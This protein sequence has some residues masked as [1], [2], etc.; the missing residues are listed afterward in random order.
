MI[1]TCP[2]CGASASAD[3][4][5]ANADARKA[6][7][8][9]SDI[10]AQVQ[11]VAF[12][13]AAMFR[14]KSRAMSWRQALRRLTEI[15]DMTGS[16]FV[17]WKGRPARPCMPG[18]WAQAVAEMTDSRDI[19]LPL[20]NHNYLRAIAYDLA[21]KA[22]RQAETQ[23]NASERTHTY[24]RPQE[25]EDAASPEEIKEILGKFKSGRKK[26]DGPDREELEQKRR[27]LIDQAQRF[28][29]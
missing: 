18:I 27:A 14:P 24:V 23:R 26:S 19:E 12:Q 13:Y 3:V 5:F 28:A 15:R 2:S 8:V 10:P 22:D 1:L 6:F 11:A 17:Q 7:A 21:E 20:N 4:W 25:P 16:G 29:A 9:Y